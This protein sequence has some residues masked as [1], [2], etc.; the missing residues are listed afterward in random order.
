LGLLAQEQATSETVQPL[1]HLY[2]RLGR[3]LELE[4]R[5]DEAIAV[6]TEMEA[7][8]RQRNDQPLLLEA[9]LRQG[10]LRCAPTPLFNA[11][12]GKALVEQALQLAQQL[13]DRAAEAKIYW[14]LTNLNN[15]MHDLN[16]AIEYG[17]KSLALA[18]ELG[19]KEQM[20][21][22]LND[23]SRAYWFSG[24]L[25]RTWETYEEAS[26]LWRELDNRPMLADS[27][28][29]L[30]GP[31]IFLGRYDEAIVLADE[32]RQISDAIGNVWGQSYSRTLIGRVYWE[33]GE[34]ERAIAIMQESIRLAQ[35][36]NSIIPQVITRS[37]LA[38]VYGELGWVDLG[39]ETAQQALAVAEQRILHLSIYP[40]T[41]LLQLH[42]LK[43][44][45]A[46]AE[47]V[48][49]KIQANRS[50]SL[51]FYEALTYLTEVEWALGQDNYEEVLFLTET[52][53]KLFHRL[54]MRSYEPWLLDIRGQALL[55]LGRPEEATAC[56]QEARQLAE[57]LGARTRLWPLLLKLSQLEP[58]PTEANRLRQ[59][60]CEIV[61]YIADHIDSFELQDSFLNLPQ[62]KAA[63]GD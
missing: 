48:M 53:L 11:V 36:V 8:A 3:A 55:A 19:L 30:V 13:N 22:T 37:D 21:F 24:Q 49:T 6:Y 47:L 34:P 32:A 12:Q 28:S 31:A 16:Q 60:A 23:V 2:T 29:S 17:E 54:K 63:L 56:W 41:V 43:G 7:T 59:Q 61:D 35:Q 10:Q 14:I 9:L 52:S 1:Q 40:L 46:G 58:D 42:L 18:R 45:L 20:A 57:A 15:F 27:L 39:L 5:F 25:D 38:T 62:I 33:R 51:T 44:D 4:S 50:K 26:R